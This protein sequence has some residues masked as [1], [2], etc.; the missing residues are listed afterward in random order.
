MPRLPKIRLS[1][2]ADRGY[3]IRLR[4]AVEN[5]NERNDIFKGKASKLIAS[6]EHLFLEADNE[7]KRKRK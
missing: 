7:P 6:L 2:A 4:Q 1:F 3:L 5:D